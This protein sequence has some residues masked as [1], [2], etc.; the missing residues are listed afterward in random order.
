L[1][2]IKK[3]SWSCVFMEKLLIALD[4]AAAEFLCKRKIRLPKFEGDTGKVAHLLS[5]LNI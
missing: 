4:C 3:S 5:K 2:T 1:D